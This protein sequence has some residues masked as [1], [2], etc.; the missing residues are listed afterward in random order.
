MFQD[1]TI[2]FYYATQMFDFH[3]SSFATFLTLCIERSFKSTIKKAAAQ[4]RIPKDLLVFI[5]DSVAQEIKVNSAEEEFFD[6]ASVSQ[7]EIDILNKLSKMEVS[8]LK[9][10]LKTGSYDETA[11]ELSIS[12]KAV[13]N[14]L[15]RIRKKL[16]G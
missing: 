16:N 13:D 10:F 4:K 6:K 2:S 5:D 12:R 3:S 14:A 7:T 11:K 15:V 8:V 9:S 1:A